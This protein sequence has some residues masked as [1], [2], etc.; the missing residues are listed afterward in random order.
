M[1]LMG[2]PRTVAPC[3]PWIEWGLADMADTPG[4]RV[5]QCDPSRLRFRVTPG[6]TRA[7]FLQE[8]GRRPC[9]GW[10]VWRESR[11]VRAGEVAVNVEARVEG[12]DLVVE[13]RPD[14]AVD[15]AAALREVGA[16][17]IAP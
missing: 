1:L 4:Q 3:A 8:L 7:N 12:R 14:P 17:P 13:L 16:A 6:G 15:V 2:C 10:V 9:A 11:L 5:E